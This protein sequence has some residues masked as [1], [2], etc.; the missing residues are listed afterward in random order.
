MSRLSRSLLTASLLLLLGVSP[1]VAQDKG[2][3]KKDKGDAAQQAD[4][5]ALIVAVDALMA[6]NAGEN[7]LPLKWEQHHFIKALG[8]KTYVP[9]SLTIDP[10][11]FTTSTT[12]GFY[13]RVAKHGETAPAPAPP[14]EAK[15]DKDKDKT[16]AAAA[17]PQYPFDY[18]FV[19]DVPPAAP[20]QPQRL[21]R[22]F[23]VEP[24]EYDVYIAVREKAKDASTPEASL[25]S[26]TLKHTITVP[27]Y[28]NTELTTSSI[29]VAEK[30]DVLSAPLS[31]D[32][33][34]ENPYTFGQ[35]KLTPS[36]TNK[37]TKKDDLN[38]F[39][40]IY[41]EQMDP[42]TKKPNMTVDFNFSRK[43]PEGGEKFFNRTEP[44]EL[45][46]STLPPTLDFSAGPQPLPGS[47]Q[48]PLGSFPEGDYHLEI[49]M[50]DKVS[51][52]TLSRDVTFTVA[53]SAV[54]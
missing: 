48:V 17:P 25:K 31:S 44:E 36:V 4:M 39:F 49:K 34:G 37:F 45:S 1:S 51:G 40:W 32:H 30:V 41:G 15:K 2:K 28:N 47:L 19:M 16:A 46:A 33:Q 22:A 21:R 20:G 27:A 8:T 23:D 9:F 53:P 24:G 50:V 3:G 54:Q 38:V 13:I 11:A 6:G 12:V 18:G 26:G 42:A 35:V 14:A 7:T 29:I 5:N 43:L 10:P 52:K